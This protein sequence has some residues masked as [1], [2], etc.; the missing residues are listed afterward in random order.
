[1]DILEKGEYNFFITENGICINEF[2]KC[3]NNFLKNYFDNPAF[4][5]AIIHYTNHSIQTVFINSFISLRFLKR[6]SFT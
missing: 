5:L 2:R 1:M 4:Y 3:F 6:V